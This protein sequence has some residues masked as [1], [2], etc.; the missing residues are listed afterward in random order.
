MLDSIYKRLGRFGM[1]GTSGLPRK[2]ALITVGQAE[3]L[4]KFINQLGNGADPNIQRVRREL[5]DALDDDVVE[6]GLQ[7]LVDNYK[8][9]NIGNIYEEMETIREQIRNGVAIDI[10]QVEARI[11]GLFDKLEE[12]VHN[13][14]SKHNELAEMAGTEVDELERKLRELQ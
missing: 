8:K 6:G 9:H 5:I 12:L 1:L 11:M 14:T 4:R 2:D 13:L 3:S 10:Q 7:T